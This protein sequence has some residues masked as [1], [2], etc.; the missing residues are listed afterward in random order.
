MEYELV[1]RRLGL[2]MKGE[3]ELQSPWSE[4]KL[5]EIK[6]ETME[7]QLEYLRMELEMKR[8]RA[9]V[10]MVRGIERN[11]VGRDGISTEV[12]K[13]GIGNETRGRTAVSLVRGIERNKVGI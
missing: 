1:S 6:L 4:K 12:P 13:N 11:E 8:E 3:G 5:K 10:L 7:Y 9:A 2:E